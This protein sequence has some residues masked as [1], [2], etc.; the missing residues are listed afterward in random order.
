MEHSRKCCYKKL[1]NSLFFHQKTIWNK[2]NNA[3]EFFTLS[4]LSPLLFCWF[5]L[6]IKS[7][8]YFFKNIL[9]STK[10]FTN[11]PNLVL[12]FVKNIKYTKIS[13]ISHFFISFFY[14]EMYKRKDW[15]GSIK[16]KY[17]TWKEIG[18]FI[19]I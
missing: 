13:F 2:N 4:D 16:I 1:F 17:R 7:I 3:M 18:Q 10:S 11:V 6:V 5:F 14:S 19:T 15:E 8:F 9:V 12:V